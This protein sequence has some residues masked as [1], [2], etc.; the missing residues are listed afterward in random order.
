[1]GRTT[2]AI[3]IVD[4]AL[5]EAEALDLVHRSAEDARLDGRHVRL[6]GRECL[7][8]GSCSYLG[9]ELDPR[10]LAGA[11]DALE[12]YGVQFSSS[13]SY[14]TTPLYE[15][16]ESLLER[17]FAAPVL[18]L[19][20]TTLAHLSALPTL[21]EDE[22]AVVLDHQVHQS[23]RLAV[24]QVQVQGTPI[25]VVRHGRID[26]LD[27]RIRE[28]AL[29]HRR[30]WYLADGVYSAY[31]DLAPVEPLRW[32]LDR[33]EALHVYLDDAHG[34]SWTGR[35]GRGFAAEALGG[36]P[37]VVI[38]VSLNKAFA[39]AGGALVLPEA[40]LRSRVRNCGGP[41]IFSGPIQP[42]LLGAAVA[43]ARIHLSPEIERLQ[44]ELRERVRLANRLARRLDLPLA[45][46]SEV[47]IRFVGLGKKQAAFDL[48]AHLLRRGFYVNPSAFPV[49]GPRNAGIRFTLTRHHQPADIEQLLAEVAE[50][51]PT[52]LA[53]AGTSRVQVDRAFG[54]RRCAAAAPRAAPGSLV[55][56]HETTIRAL[57][58]AAWNR[59]LGARGSF[60]AATL[61]AFEDVFGAR[62]PRENRWH[63]HY[64]RVVDG[65]GRPVL[66]TF[67]TRALWK[68]DLLAA[69]KVS[70]A[71]EQRR[72]SDPY[73]LTSEVLAM[74]C[75]LS[76]GEHLELDRGGDWRGALSLLLAAVEREREESGAASLVLRDL[77]PADEELRAALE[78]EGFAQ[79]ALPESMLLEID[80][81]TPQEFLA[82]RTRH[83]RKFHAKHVAPWQDAWDMRVLPR[84]AR[85]GAREW[86]HLHG[87]YLAV[88][89]RQLG[90]NTF[91]LPPELLPRLHACPG[92]EILL[93]RLRPE[94]GGDPGAP[95]Q[96]FVAAHA[97]GGHYAPVLGGLDYRYA[98]SHG[99]YRQLLARSVQRAQS[100][101]ARRVAFGM[102]SELEKA[103][104]GA[105]PLQRVLYVQSHDRYHHD[106]LALIAADAA[107]GW[108]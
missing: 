44:A 69:A 42:P 5:R 66:T 61:A 9:L 29:R 95:P 76:E 89:R 15:E 26:E 43:S 45:S 13:R 57:D 77:D 36:H 70:K 104:F 81:R 22:D 41:V 46:A 3:D 19:P 106:L 7:H 59:T 51:L 17:I 33:H 27:E 31:G 86:A 94:H 91:P 107:L 6:D 85:L 1:M 60:D 64:Y 18:V 53:L 96:G 99:L 32:L 40:R 28:L 2:R 55:C 16:L 103:R 58:P 84:D 79:V 105:R 52:S 14:L 38:A 71:V 75:L 8:F 54:L 82:R 92:W 108:G 49:V 98:Q 68:D 37:R 65:G 90:L 101:G 78:A 73:F 74:G 102:G 48:T 100:L 67:F 21:V 25:E 88:Q 35:H 30:V 23:V 56:H 80:W 87:L 62:Q 47:P 34:M 4:A 50:R 10:L 12:R 11:R 72:A 83:E 39:A 24:A 93:F 97:A 63:F 20:S